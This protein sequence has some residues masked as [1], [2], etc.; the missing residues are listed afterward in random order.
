MTSGADHRLRRIVLAVGAVVAT[1]A[2]LAFVD[3]LVP[4]PSGPP[5]S[6]YATERRGLAAWAELLRRQGHPVRRVRG[7]PEELRREETAVVLDPR[8]LLAADARRLAGLV[9]SG[10]RLI[11]GGEAP[12]AW[13]R[14]LAPDLE[15]APDGDE[16]IRGRLRVVTAQGGHWRTLGRARSVVGDRRRSLVASQELGRGRLVLVADSSPLQNQLLAQ[17][18]DAVLAVELAGPRGRPVAF[19]ES[20]H[21]YGKASG[22]AALPTGWRWGLGL[23]ALA[24]LT[25]VLSQ[26]RRLGP[27]DVAVRELPPPRAAYVEAIA[28]AMLRA[29]RTVGQNPAMPSREPDRP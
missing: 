17:A 5:S 15:W 6:S 25:W 4:S 12:E 19:L 14:F 2:V 13:L 20:V 26:A 10:G 21:G 9:R 23:L 7:G 1:L 27:P 11:A 16:V 28:L 24:A 29:D 8:D 18:D 3:R 22:L